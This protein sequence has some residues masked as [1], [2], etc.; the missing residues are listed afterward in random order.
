V[1]YSKKGGKGKKNL[2]FA[3]KVYNEVVELCFK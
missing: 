3:E 2:R 1:Y